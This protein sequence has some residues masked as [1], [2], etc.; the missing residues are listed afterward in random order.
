MRYRKLRIAWSVGGGV[1]CLLLIVL[2]VRSYS[3]ADSGRFPAFHRTLIHIQSGRGRIVA[4]TFPYSN[5]WKAGSTPIEHIGP[6]DVLTTPVISSRHHL[7]V[8]NGANRIAIIPYWPVII[9]VG[10]VVP[11][12]WLPW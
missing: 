10:F 5:E 9:S 6:E 3:I 11:S 1:L 7:Q 8:Y 2:W 12:P 4:F